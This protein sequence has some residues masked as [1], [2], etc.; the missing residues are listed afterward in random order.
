VVA[1]DA[2]GRIK[3]MFDETGKPVNEVV[4][5]DPVMVLGLSEPPQ[6][7]DSFVTVKSEKIA[8]AQIEERQ[9]GTAPDQQA[10]AALSLEDLF[11]QFSAGKAK[12]LTLIV[13]VDVRGSLQPIV[14]KLKDLSENNE[15]GIH[16]RILLADIGN[17]GENDVMLASASSAIIV[18]FNVEIDNAARRS[19]DSHA[20]DIRVYNV[21][22]KLFEDIEL[23]L[24]GMLEPKYA[25]K[26]VGTAEIRQTFRIPKVGTIAGS[27]IRDGEARRNARARVKRAGKLLGDDLPVSS[28][29]RH[30]EDVREVRSGF[31]C[32]I[33]LHGFDDFEV[34]DI[35]EFYVNERV[36]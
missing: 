12:E 30:N 36:N 16:I 20:V 15:T 14:D 11:A 34:G 25:E 4:P 8:R 32:G 29:R 7:G 22:Y 27:Y 35:I 21:I 19:A 13:K 31:E 2:Y 3:A 28:L 26:V 6:P 1:R 17:I 24:K 5:S 18:G 23:A 10:R 33:G 9:S